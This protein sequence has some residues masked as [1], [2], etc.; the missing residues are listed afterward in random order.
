MQVTELVRHLRAR[1]PSFL[2]KV[3]GGIDWESIETSTKL[4]G[5][6][7][8][9]VITD[10]KAEGSSTQNVVRQDVAEEF[11]VC[12]EFPQATGDEKGRLV[13]DQLDAV[14]AE[15]CRALVGWK[16]LPSYDPIQYVGRQML[17]NNRAKAV[18]RFSFVTGFQLG[19]NAVSDPPET[20]Q[21]LEQDG[22]PALEGLDI[23][24]DF[25]DPIVDRNLSATGPD[26]RIE[27]KTTEELQT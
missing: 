24:V 5:L 7:A 1:C 22:L 27:I 13:G 6:R 2:N 16:P 25:I 8:H 4:A 10:E 14:R 15:L 21:E 9:V 20:W 3:A 18:Y 23:D 17:L 26:G 19:R 11:D 12:V